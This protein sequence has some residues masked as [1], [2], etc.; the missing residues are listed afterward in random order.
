MQQ[1]RWPAFLAQL[2]GLLVAA[3][4]TTWTIAHIVPVAVYTPEGMRDVAFGWPLP[5]Y[6]QDLSRYSASY[7]PTT[8]TIIGDRVSPVPTTVDWLVLAG[9]VALT[10]LVLWAVVATLMRIFG[11]VLRRK[12]A[13]RASQDR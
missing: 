9:N 11:P 2:A 3:L 5:W 7:Y 6:Y 13:D 8:V 4:A 12:L 1:R 10:A